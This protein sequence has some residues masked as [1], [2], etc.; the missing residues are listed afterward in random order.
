MIVR[1][2]DDNP[3]AE[4]REPAVVA[5]KGCATA[6]AVFNL[7]AMGAL[8]W[9]FAGG[10]YSGLA[11]ALWYRGGAVGFLIF[12]A[13]LPGGA[14]LLPARRRPALAPAALAWMLCVWLPF[15]AYVLMSG[16]GI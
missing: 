13:L 1:M 5:G 15:V 8:A 7:L 11:Q 3:R 2:A 16:G 14:L 6:L 12:G 4:P 9:S 10:P